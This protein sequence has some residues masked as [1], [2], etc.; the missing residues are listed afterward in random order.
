M[1]ISFSLAKII[2]FLKDFYFKF[3]KSIYI[4]INKKVYFVVI[5]HI[6]EV[7]K[8]YW[9]IQQLQSNMFYLINYNFLSFFGFFS[10]VW[11]GAKLADVLELVGIP[12]LTSTTQSGGKHVE[13]VSVDKCKVTNSAFQY[14]I[15]KLLLLFSG[16]FSLMKFFCMLSFM[17]G[18]YWCNAFWIIKTLGRKWWPLQGIYST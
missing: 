18:L 12:N 6:S 17:E 11:G 16:H 3:F 14:I 5:F 10:A 15:L 2:Y 4:M 9:D 8:S 7:S 1:Y 13:F